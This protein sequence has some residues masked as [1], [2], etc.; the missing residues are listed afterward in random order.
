[1]TNN[2]LSILH[3]WPY[4]IFMTLV[5]HDHFIG[6][7][8]EG[9]RLSDLTAQGHKAELKAS[10]VLSV[11]DLPKSLLGSQRTGFQVILTLLDL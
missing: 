1:M 6:K 9:Q 5:L 7:E 2:M 11:V 10:S 3:K 4:F 8:T